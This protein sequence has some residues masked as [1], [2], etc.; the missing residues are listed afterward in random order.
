M[1][2]LTARQQQVLDYITR[3]IDAQGYPPT[4]RDIAAHMGI[5]STF[6]VTRHLDALEKKGCLT[7]SGHARS[8]VPAQ[9]RGNR[10][11]LPIV[12]TVRAGALHPAIEDIQ[13]HFAIDASRVRGRGCFFLKV[14]GDSMIEAG[15]LD[16]DLALVQPQP[17]AEDRE[18]VVALVDGEATLKRFFRES[19]RIRLEPA[20]RKLAPI[21]VGPDR[22]VAIIGKVTGIYRDLEPS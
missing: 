12:G 16:G 15:I 10:A 7:R 11:E 5:S 1:P 2:K 18:I 21:L 13:G 20:N 4:L 9:P 14:A 6:G 19:G 8:I 22:D 3:F 17:T